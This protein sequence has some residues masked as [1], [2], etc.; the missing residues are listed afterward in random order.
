[1]HVKTNPAVI[2]TV[3]PVSVLSA[4]TVHRA[5]S[6]DQS[7]RMTLWLKRMCRSTACSAA[8]SLTYERIVEPSAIDFDAR[9]GLNEYPSV[10]MSESER[11][12]G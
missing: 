5:S 10:Y 6:E 1:V 7:A 2:V 9:Q 3:S 12:P 11:I 4:V 8:V